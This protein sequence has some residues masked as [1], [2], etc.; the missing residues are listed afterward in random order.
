MKQ[1]AEKY[2]VTCTSMRNIVSFKNRTG[3]S[4]PF[5]NNALWQLYLKSVRCE[6][7][8]KS[9]AMTS[10]VLCSHFKIGRPASKSKNKHLAVETFR[11]AS[12]ATHTDRKRGYLVQIRLSEVWAS[13]GC[14][15]SKNY[16]LSKK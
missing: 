13:L 11:T 6:E 8:R 3:D 1:I 9:S 14:E 7:C 2:N 16:L 15:D 5:W 10:R 4:H 12:A